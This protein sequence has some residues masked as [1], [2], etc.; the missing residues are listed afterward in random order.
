MVMVLQVFSGCMGAVYKAK[1]K[2][3]T[4]ERMRRNE[5]LEKPAGGGGG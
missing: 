2:R 4:R 3:R 1:G 5:E